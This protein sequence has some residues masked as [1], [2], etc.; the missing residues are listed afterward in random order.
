MS[1][2]MVLT[3]MPA[4]AFAAAEEPTDTDVPVAEEEAQNSEEEIITDADLQ[5]PVQ[6]EED[7]EPIV[8]SVE[9]VTDTAKVGSK[10]GDSDDLLQQYVD[11]KVKEELAAS[12]SSRQYSR[13]RK[14]NLTGAELKLYKAL[15]SQ[16]KKV[17]SGELTDTSFRISADEIFE[18]TSF[19]P[20]DLDVNKLFV[21]NGEKNV[22]T[23]EAKEN[24]IKI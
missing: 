5:E 14:T 8:V 12:D 3:Y 21:Y 9:P 10:L 7:S 20:D 22:L 24:F 16:I 4:M 18:K 6:E 15:V 11:D 17:A 1:L 23:D 13:S 19:T 2:T